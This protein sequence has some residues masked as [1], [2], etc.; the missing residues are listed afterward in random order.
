MWRRL[1]QAIIMVR[2]MLALVAAKRARGQEDSRRSAA[3]A[4]FWAEVREGQ[5]EAEAHK[6]AG[7]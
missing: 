3:R 1:R 2:E 4:R 5:R 7:A 6:E